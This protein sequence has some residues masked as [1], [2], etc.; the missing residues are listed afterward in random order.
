MSV[1]VEAER[2]DLRHGERRRVDEV[3]AIEEPVNILVNGD[4]VLSLLA[5]PEYRKELAL[6][7]LFDQ[8]VLSS[9]DDVEK[10]TV[11]GESVDVST[12]C[13]VDAAKLKSVGVSNLQMA[14]RSLTANGFFRVIGGGGIRV[15]ASD[16]AVQ[17]ADLVRMFRLLDETRLFQSTGGVHVAALFEE[18][19]L[20]SRVEDVGRHNAVDKAV[21]VGLLSGIDFSASLLACSGRQPADMVLKAARMGIPVVSSR[22]APIRSGIVA[23][24]KSGL[25]LVC[26]VRDG[27]MNVYTHPH[28]ILMGDAVGF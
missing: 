5:T 2:I 17:A 25:T 11:K 26:F 23:A 20:I 3:V 22:A 13:P 24:E 19:R 6:G 4:H 27:R 15:V 21:G 7:W 1:V 14:A 12:T 16:Y 8:G 18:G 9:L 28:R 10:V